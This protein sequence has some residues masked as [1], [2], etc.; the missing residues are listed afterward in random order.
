VRDLLVL[1]VD[2]R[3]GATAWLVHRDKL[4]VALARERELPDHTAN[5]DE[6]LR[7]KGEGRE[8]AIDCLEGGLRQL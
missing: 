6:Q 3:D 8:R 5:F 2:V 4:E 7:E 1:A